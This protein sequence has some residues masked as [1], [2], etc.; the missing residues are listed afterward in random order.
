MMIEYKK[1]VEIVVPDEKT[2]DCVL[3]ELVNKRALLSEYDVYITI[4]ENWLKGLK[5]ENV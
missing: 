2:A 4:K 1:K 3:N 5:N